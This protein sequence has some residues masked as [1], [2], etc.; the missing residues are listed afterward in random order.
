V[1]RWGIP[2]GIGDGRSNSDQL[3]RTCYP[4]IPSGLSNVRCPVECE[5]TGYERQL[6]SDLF[7]PQFSPRSLHPAGEATQFLAKKAM[8]EDGPILIGFMVYADFYA[9]VS[10]IYRP[11]M[12]P[13]NKKIGGH[14]VT[15]MGFGPGYI[16]AV[17]SWGPLF[18]DNGAFKIDPSAINFGYYLPGPMVGAQLEVLP[19]PIPNNQP[20]R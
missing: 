18:A 14:A 13:D 3:A 12:S 19:I 9:Y 17:N 8:M 1:N 5:N 15:G 6:P 4:Q 16:L 11:H 20:Y 10:G 2:T 7:Y